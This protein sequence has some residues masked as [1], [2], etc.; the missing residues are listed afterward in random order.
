MQIGNPAQLDSAREA[1][2]DQFDAI[3]IASESIG[4]REARAIRCSIALDK[5]RTAQGYN[6]RIFEGGRACGPFNAVIYA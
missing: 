1:L 5:P 6:W 4:P 3:W 2:R